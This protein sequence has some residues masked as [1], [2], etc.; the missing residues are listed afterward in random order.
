MRWTGKMGA[1]CVDDVGCRV[2]CGGAAPS[3]Q[4]VAQ[5]VRRHRAEVA[6]LFV[7][8][9]ELLAAAGAVE[10][11]CAAVDGS[12]VSGNASRFAN[13]DQEQLEVRITVLQAAIDAAAQAWLAGAGEADG[14]G[15]QQLPGD[16][17]R[18]DDD[19]GQDGGGPRG[20]G[21]RPLAPRAATLARRPPAQGK[22]APR[23][24]PAAPRS[25]AAP[26]TAAR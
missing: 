22:P 3:H 24:Q 14:A 6:R 15:S 4:A 19:D 20:G 25:P 9:L 16:D 1:A 2:I 18:D 8:V 10:G 23:G 11:H 17:D 5:F 13:L 26:S 7:Q 12:P 21:P